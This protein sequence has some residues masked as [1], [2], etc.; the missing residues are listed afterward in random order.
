MERDHFMIR[1]TGNCFERVW[2][3]ADALC[4]SGE[5]RD[6]LKS[7]GMLLA[8]LR[9]DDFPEHMKS[10]FADVR[11]ELSK[12]GSIDSTVDALA[13]DDQERIAGMLLS[14]YTQAARLDSELAEVISAN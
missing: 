10:K 14:L 4:G 7:V 9:N 12:L 1:D 3:A 2:R 6:R 13:V 5:L 11:S 8:P